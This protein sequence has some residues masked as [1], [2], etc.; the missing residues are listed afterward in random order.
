LNTRRTLW[1]GDHGT[2]KIVEQFGKDLICV[3][4]RY[5]SA[6]RKRYKTI[7]LIYET[8]EWNPDNSRI[9]PN[10]IVFIKVRPDEITLRTVIKQ[11]GGKWNAVKR[12]WEMKYKTVKQ[13]KLESR[14]VSPF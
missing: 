2:K 8:H 3:R 5:Y 7:E 10:K 6:R 11:H 12:V 9:H 1:P 14:I 4:Y 13:L